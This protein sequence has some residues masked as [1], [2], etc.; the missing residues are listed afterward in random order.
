VEIPRR[1][2][3][4]YDHERDGKRLH[5]QHN[6]VFALMKDGNWRTL[7]QIAVGTGDPEASVSARLRDLRKDRFGAHG[8][9]RRSCGNGLFEYRLR[10]NHTDLFV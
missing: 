2:G 3:S 1:D 10:V 6:R 4:T 5:K 7:G 9:E 8:V